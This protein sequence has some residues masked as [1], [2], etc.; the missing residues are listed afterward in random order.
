VH[1]LIPA[2]SPKEFVIKRGDPM[3]VVMPFRRDEPLEAHVVTDEASRDEAMKLAQRDQET[4]A[5]GTGRYK[6]LFVEDTNFSPLYPALMQ[7]AGKAEGS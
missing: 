6:E 2:N 1:A 4:F 7:R 3:C 5:N